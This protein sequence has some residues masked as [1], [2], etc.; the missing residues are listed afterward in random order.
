M[1]N[2]LASHQYAFSVCR[3]DVARWGPCLYSEEFI[4]RGLTAV[5]KV[6]SMCAVFKA[7]CSTELADQNRMVG[8]ALPAMADSEFFLSISVNRGSGKR[9]QA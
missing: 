7:K 8:R 5:R 4:N 9:H 3:S 1:V 2:E 6:H